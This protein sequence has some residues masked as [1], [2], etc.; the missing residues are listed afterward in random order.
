MQNMGIVTGSVF[1]RNQELEEANKVLMKYKQAYK[2]V[3]DKGK[4]DARIAEKD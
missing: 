2:K 1:Q 3:K 4:N